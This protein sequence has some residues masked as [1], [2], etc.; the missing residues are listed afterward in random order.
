[1]PE[2]GK[3]P[4]DIP[5]VNVIEDVRLREILKAIVVNLETLYNTRGDL[6]NSALLIKR[7]K[8][9]GMVGVDRGTLFAKA[10]DTAP[11]ALSNKFGL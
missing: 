3:L 2:S 10:I 5:S 7:A 8:E 9:L 4:R 1:M 11:H 6:D